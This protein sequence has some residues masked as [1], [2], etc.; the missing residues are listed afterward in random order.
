L[1]AAAEAVFRH[2]WGDRGA[3]DYEEGEGLKYLGGLQDYLSENPCARP[4]QSW[5]TIQ[6]DRSLRLDLSRRDHGAVRTREFEYE[7]GLKVRHDPERVSR[8]I[9]GDAVCCGAQASETKSK[10]ERG[11]G[12]GLGGGLLQGLGAQERADEEQ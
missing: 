3:S 4:D 5:E 9:D 10:L 2:A 11:L 6:Q 1:A 12:G 7:R 8:G